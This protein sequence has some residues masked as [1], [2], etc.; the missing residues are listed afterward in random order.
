MKNRFI[1]MLKHVLIVTVIHFHFIQYI[2]AGDDTVTINW[3]KTIVVSKTIIPTLQV[4]E[5]PAVR[6]DIFAY[7]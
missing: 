6:P 2:C 3:N 4:V 1:V 7:S 5:N